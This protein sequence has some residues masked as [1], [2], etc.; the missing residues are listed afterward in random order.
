[1][2]RAIHAH[3]ECLLERLARLRRTQCDD[4]SFRAMFVFEINRERN[5][6]QIESAD[7]VGTIA[8]DGLGDGIEVGIF[9]Q[10]N[11]FD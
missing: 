4:G 9:D 2:N 1:V 7:D 11:L 6:A 3:R 10:W 8:F 5:R